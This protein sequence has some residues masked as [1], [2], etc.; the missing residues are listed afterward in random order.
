MRTLDHPNIIRFYETYEDDMYI[1]FVMEFCQGG[2]LLDH[3]LQ[4]G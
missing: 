2:E 1:H 3:L 4:N